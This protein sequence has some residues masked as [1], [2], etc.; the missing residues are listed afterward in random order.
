MTDSRLGDNWSEGEAYERYV[1][2][3]SRLF[4]AEF[5]E[6]L[7]LPGAGRWLDVG[8]GTGAL[9]EAILRIAGP[10][11]VTGVDAVAGFIEFARAT[12]ADARVAFEVGDAQSLPIDSAACDAV[13]CGFALNFFPRPGPAIEEMARVTKPGGVVAAYVWDY[14]GRMQFMRHF[15]N[16]ATALDSAAVHLDEGRRFPLCNPGPLAKL[17]QAAGLTGVDVRPIDAWTVFA[18][19]DDYW[20]P[21]LGQ[22]GPAPSYLRSLD[23]DVRSAL[24]DRIHDALPVAIDGSIPLM[25]RAWAVRGTR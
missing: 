10:Q 13:V 12:I 11:A 5:L 3:W 24:R 23:G 9:T 21:F 7:S 16:A 25:A 4:A 22:Q 14:A 19:F 20:L 17:F 1:G 8:C 18:D 15:W 2:R 6:W